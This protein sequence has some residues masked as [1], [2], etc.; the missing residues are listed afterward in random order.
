MILGA[1][2]IAGALL[3]VFIFAGLAISGL[4][5]TIL[6]I[7]LLFRR[8]FYIGA[9]LTIVG[10]VC[11][12]P[13]LLLV[14][15]SPRKTETFVVNINLT[16]PQDYSGIP[17][18]RWFQNGPREFCAFQG[19]V[20]TTII[21]PDGQKLAER[22]FLLVIDRDAEG[23]YR[24]LGHSADTLTF[25]ESIQRLHME[26]DMWAKDIIPDDDIEKFA[27]DTKEWIKADFSDRQQYQGFF[28]RRPGYTLSFRYRSRY[29]S[30]HKGFPYTYQVFL[31]DSRPSQP[32][33]NEDQ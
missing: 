17:D 11:M 22:F 18:K 23:I 12:I 20:E 27:S 33:T 10:P 29:T 9:A 16:Q 1:D 14:L 3:V 19:I 31:R 8:S 2:G 4:A 30:R 25:R 26:L 7:I 5:I 28:V 32:L 24:I 6:G 15:H 13:M 21:L